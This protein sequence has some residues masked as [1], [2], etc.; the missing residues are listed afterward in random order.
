MHYSKLIGTRLGD[1]ITQHLNSTFQEFIPRVE[2]SQLDV[3]YNVPHPSL[4]L[5]IHDNLTRN[6]FFIDSTFCRLRSYFLGKFTS[7]TSLIIEL[8]T[9]ASLPPAQFPWNRDINFLSP[10]NSKA[11]PSHYSRRGNI[12]AISNGYISATKHDFSKPFFLVASPWCV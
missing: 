7:W 8:G 9:A 4:L 2:I 6:T 1:T 10:D 11:S 5:H 12:R 3:M